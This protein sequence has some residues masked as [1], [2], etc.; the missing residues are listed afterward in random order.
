MRILI[1]TTGSRGDIQP[2]VA[3]GAGL[4]AAGHRVRLATH[5]DFE[6]F[7]RRH[8]LDFFPLAGNSRA[9]HASA[10][11]RRMLHAG[12]N[13]F[14]FMREFARLRVA[15]VPDMMAR[16]Y[17]AGREAD[18]IVAT[19]TALLPAHCV[20]EKL[21]RPVLTAH[22]P[23]ATPNRLV[24]SCLFPGAP[25]WLPFGRS[26]YN[27]LTHLA[28]GEYFWQLF[29]RSVNRGRREILGMAPFPFLGP[30]PSYF[31]AKP[32]VYGYSPAVVPRP[33][34]WGPQHQITGYWFLDTAGEWTPP[35]A[36]VEFLKAG[37]APV[38]VGFGSMPSRRPGELTRCV[39]G[40]LDRAGQR[41]ILLTGWGGLAAPAKSSRF[42]AV[43]SV[44]HDWLFPRVAAVVHHGGAGTTAAALRAGVP[45]VVVP[46]MGD[47]GFWARRVHA[48]G[49]GPPPVPRR[50]LTREGLAAAVE[51]A[52]ADPK[53]RRR[54]T[55]LGDRIRSED[56]TGKAAEFIRNHFS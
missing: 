41:G 45:S 48:L 25:A 47:Q 22:Y 54:A 21:G 13:P 14:T 4:T 51:T 46:F 42:L 18:L 29:R 19:T 50:R 23:P 40:A 10:T 2:Y 8:G 36:V 1:A 55:F 33:A 38:C 43:P 56:G 52:V 11:G 27:V 9:M 49:V 31:S 30:S 37:P 7:I 5:V 35:A 28:G 6:D 17:E 34:E 26:V 3:L 20:A 32:M 15:Q 12:A 44:P 53:V 16:C 24:E 39:T